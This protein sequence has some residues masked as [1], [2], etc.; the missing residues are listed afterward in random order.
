MTLFLILLLA[1]VYIMGIVLG[2]L[3]LDAAIARIDR[4]EYP[5]QNF[6]AILL[7]PLAVFYAIS[8][9]LIER[10]VDEYKMWGYNR[11]RKAEDR[12]RDESQRSRT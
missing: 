3:Y 10:A 5:V 4:A 8:T 11:K 9:G 1:F 6:F 12:R 2:Y 7:W